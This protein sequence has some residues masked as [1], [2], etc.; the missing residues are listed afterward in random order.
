MFYSLQ[1]PGFRRIRLIVFVCCLAFWGNRLS[2][3]SPASPPPPQDAPSKTESTATPAT[4]PA[5]GPNEEVSS[6]DTPATFKVRVN[7][8]L[9]RVVVRDSQGKVLSNLKQQ[10]FQ[11]YDNR[12]P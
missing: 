12:T 2:A 5:A 8:V 7:L 10:D 3:Q 11:L 1:L 6:H 9:V 4:A